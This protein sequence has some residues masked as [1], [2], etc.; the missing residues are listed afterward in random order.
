MKYSNFLGN[1]LLSGALAVLVVGVAGCAKNVTPGPADTTSSVTGALTIAS[2]PQ[3]PTA[4]EAIDEKGA[5]VWG[6]LAADGKF[7]FS[8]PKAHSYHFNIV[9][10][11]GSEPLVFPRASK[12]LD[13]TVKIATGGAVI[14]LGAIRHLA[15]AQADGFMVKSAPS[16]SSVQPKTEA[17]DGECENGKDSK[18][19]AACVDEPESAVCEQGADSGADGECENGKDSKTGAACVDAPDADDALDADPTKPMAV[20]EHNAPDAVDGCNEAS[21]GD[22]ETA[23]DGAEEAD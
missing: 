23:D 10:P 15:A 16:A 20:A 4:V 17:A 5:K 9:L 8:L 18:T 22:G 21:D 12:R 3:A 13:T 7:S 19:G 6:V 14:A 1:A 2:F 11:S